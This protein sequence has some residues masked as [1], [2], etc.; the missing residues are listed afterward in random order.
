MRKFQVRTL[1]RRCDKFF[2]G[3]PVCKMTYTLLHIRE[4]IL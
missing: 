1:P 4:L 2:Q 3:A